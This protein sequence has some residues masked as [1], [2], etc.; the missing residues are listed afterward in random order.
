MTE[1]FVLS[2]LGADERVFKFIDFSGYKVTFVKWIQPLS[3]ESI[4]G[5]TERLSQQIKSAKPILIGLSFGGMMAMEI[6]KII[7]GSKIILISS[8]KTRKEIP[9][10]F[11]WIGLMKI[12]KLVPA[13][14]LKSSNFFTYYAFGAHSEGDRALLKAILIDTDAIFLKWA[15]DQIVKWENTVAP[16]FTFHIHGTKDKI[17]PL[18]LVESDLEI[19]GG[20]HLMIM[21]HAKEISGLLREK[22]N[23]PTF[24]S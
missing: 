3:N 1:I 12:H 2:G 16:K 18:A 20:S 10:Y 23:D 9:F 11:R 24:S 17:L 22:I 15:I 4:E 19:K 6:G 5:Y 8:A 13:R 7:E 14:F 21:S